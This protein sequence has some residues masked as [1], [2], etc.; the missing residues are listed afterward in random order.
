MISQA[1]V[2]GDIRHTCDL[3]SFWN[4][5]GIGIPL[6]APLAYKYRISRLSIYDSLPEELK[7]RI[8]QCNYY[9]R[10]EEN[11]CGGCLKCLT[12]KVYETKAYTLE[13]TEQILNNYFAKKVHEFKLLGVGGARHGYTDC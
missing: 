12:R 1:W 2:Q 13:E 11:W 10:K 7:S 6:D 5:T 9:K 3:I 8:N 4:D